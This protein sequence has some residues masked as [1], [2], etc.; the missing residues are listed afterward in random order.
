MGTARLTIRLFTFPRPLSHLPTHLV[1]SFLE[2]HGG[3]YLDISVGGKKARL[4]LH[5]GTGG[6]REKAEPARRG[7]G[8]TPGRLGPG[9]SGDRGV[10]GRRPVSRQPASLSPGQPSLQTG[11][12]PPDVCPRICSR[13]VMHDLCKVK[14]PWWCTMTSDPYI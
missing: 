13:S 10:Q 9:K 2:L 14:T 12:Q 4:T 5:S 1:S 3:T 11:Y 7:V 8:D 6:W